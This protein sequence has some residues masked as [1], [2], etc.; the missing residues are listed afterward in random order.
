MTTKQPSGPVLYRFAVIADTH[1]NQSED[2]ASSF[3]PLNRLANP[4][5]RHV[6]E[7]IERMKPEF[8]LHL[9]D[10]VHPVP[11]LPTYGQAARNFF[12]L[13]E[14]LSMPVHLT[15][16]NHDVGDK[17]VKTAPVGTVT[18]EYVRLYEST[19]GKSWFSWDQGDAHFVVI[20]AQLINS[21]LDEEDEHRRWLESDLAEHAGQRIFV[22]THYPPYVSEPDEPGNY[23]NIDEP[24]RSWLLGLLRR[25]RVEAVFCGHV[26]NFWYDLHGSTE[27]YILPSTAFVRQDYSEFQRIVPPGPEGGRADADK[28]GFFL[29]DV[30]ETGHVAHFVPTSGLTRSTTEAA[31]ASQPEP[32]RVHTKTSRLDNFGVDLRHPWA[33][34][35]ELPPSG[36]LEEFERKRARNDYP[37]GAL[38]NMGIRL[39]RVPIQDILQ[40]Q[41][42]ARVK[43]AA[44]VGNRFQVYCFGVPDA[45]A[46][47]A[48]RD[49]AHAVATLEVTLPFA[50]MAASMPALG[51]LRRSLGIPIALSK[52]RRHEDSRYDGIKYGHLIFTGW[53]EAEAEQ[54]GSILAQAGREGGV[55]RLVFRVG[56]ARSPLE[57]AAAVQPLCEQHG[58]KATL[59]VRLAGDDPAG[60]MVDD[61]RNAH[62]VLETACA[63][64]THPQTDFVIDTFMDVDRGY[65]M[66]N[67]L[68]DRSYNLRLAGRAFQRLHA[69]WATRRTDSPMP[70]TVE[71]GPGILRLAAGDDRFDALAGFDLVHRQPDRSAGSSW[72]LQDTIPESSREP[73]NGP[74]TGRRPIASDL[75]TTR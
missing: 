63:A 4:R 16:G 53:V 32:P 2:Q 36:A 52:L 75:A 19:F 6:V 25:H 5:T 9:G 69:W 38:W 51:A 28:L 72:S 1:V 60:A 23:D 17:P 62:R 44:A 64:F 7:M 18:S 58:C 66:R 21:G 42:R 20:N 50:D 70:V 47:A 12:D 26:H 33:E 14:P 35:V 11:A 61:V 37:I 29:V 54:F 65:F 56:Q 57:A 55:D 13:L 40:P 3:F 48:L 27:I 45:E 73:E 8:V 46:V 31:G 49:C 41:T 24:G 74:C 22:A 34:V 30:H 15:P 67:G 43:V 68:M 10:I 71:H 39:V 59:A